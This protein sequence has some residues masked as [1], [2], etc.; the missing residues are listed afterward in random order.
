MLVRPIEDKAT[1]KVQIER[2]DTLRVGQEFGAV[3]WDAYLSG[4]KLEILSAHK[5]WFTYL[6]NSEVRVG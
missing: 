5:K 1:K 4:E 6:I 3:L 2:C